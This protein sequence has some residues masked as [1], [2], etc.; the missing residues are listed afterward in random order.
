VVLDEFEIS[1]GLAGFGG[2]LDAVDAFGYAVETLGDVD[3]DGVPDLA[4]GTNLDD[5]G[6]FFTGA[7]WILFLNADGTV[8]AEQKISAME[9]GF[10]GALNQGDRFGSGVASLGDLDGDGVPEIAVGTSF[11]DATGFDD[12]AVWVLFLDAAGTVKSELRIDGSTP[13]LTGLIPF[14]ARFGRSVESLGDLDGNGVAEL[15]VGAWK[16]GSGSVFVLFL[17][18]AANVLSATKIAEGLSG[19][20]GD[21]TGN[22]GTGLA[23]LGDMD[24]DGVTELAVGANAADNWRGEAWMLFLNADGTV[25]SH[26]RI[27]HGVGGF[28]G[29][30]EPDDLFGTS[31]GALPDRDGNGAPELA[32]GAVWD[33][34]GSSL[35]GAV[36]ILALSPDG[37]VDS[38]QKIS[39][40]EGGFGGGLTAHEFFGG[41]LA[42]IDTDG[43]GQAS[44]AVG[45]GN[46]DDFILVP[47]PGSVWMLS[48]NPALWRDHGQGL[49]GATGEPR[50]VGT[51]ALAANSPARLSLA[52]A[53]PL[54][55]AT[56]VVGLSQLSAPFKGGTMFPFPQSIGSLVLTDGVGALVLNATWPAGV[57]SGSTFFSQAWVIDA[58]GPFGLT[59]S[60]G[61]SG[62]AP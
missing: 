46:D 40:S 33:D 62:R 25:K 3:G 29:L 35:A 36:W 19:F 50:L 5:D 41:G 18:S 11:G 61:V 27:A 43:D 28:G 56:F 39:D 30:L 53:A 1:E 59:A 23:R 60:N 32:V 42:A 2:D 15:A 22:L 17:D 8:K 26:Q 49:G 24:G 58:T 47:E 6:G 57:P 54:A 14:G 45:A 55:P 52:G 9:G 4:V 21:V 7:V 20:S 10:G 13:A 48:L 34:D 37:S 31:L 44:L 51:G 12:G 38:W 16:D